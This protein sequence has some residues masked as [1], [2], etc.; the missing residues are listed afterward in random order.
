MLKDLVAVARLKT[1][2]D[3]CVRRYRGEDRSLEL[4]QVVVLLYMLVSVVHLLSRDD[5]RPV[6]CGGGEG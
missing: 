2:R 3:V 5:G 6:M 1:R 4:M